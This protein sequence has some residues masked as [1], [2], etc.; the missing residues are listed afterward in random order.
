M[1]A[2]C[3]QRVDVAGFLRDGHEADAGLNR[4]RQATNFDLALD[5]RSEPAQ[6]LFGVGDV[7]QDQ[8]EFIP[9]EPATVSP[10]RMLALTR[11]ANSVR[12]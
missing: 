6:S 2:C 10:G 7:A 9:A 4:Q 5:H 3:K 8:A 12:S 11:R 1:S